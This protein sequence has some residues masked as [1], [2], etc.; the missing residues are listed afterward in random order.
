MKHYSNMMPSCSKCGTTCVLRQVKST[1]NNNQGKYFIS[2][3]ASNGEYGHTW[4]LVNNLPLKKSV[5]A[6]SSSIRMLKF[7]KPGVGGAI[8]GRLDDKRFV[9]T[10]VF[11]ELGGG[12]G[13]KLGRDKLKEMIESFGGRVT[14]SISGKTNYVVVG[15][16][17]GMKC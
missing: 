17:P 3:P 13:L 5:D 12:F 6:A 1:R 9:A 14:G 11:P 4:E 10:G 7:L 8:A 16:D 2:C 15:D